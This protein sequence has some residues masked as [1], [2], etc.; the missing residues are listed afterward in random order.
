[1]EFSIPPFL[2]Y[3]I[4]WGATIGAVWFI[5]EKAEETVTA[6]TKRSISN[7]L[8][9]INPAGAV[10]SWPA[11]FASVFDRVF[12]ERHLSWRCFWR[13][14][15]ASLVSVTIM[16]FIWGIQ[17]PAEFS[18]FLLAGY[19]SIFKPVFIVLVIVNFILDYLSLLESRYVIRWMSKARS[20]FSIRAGLAIDCAASAV[21]ALASYW[22]NFNILFGFLNLLLITAISITGFHPCPNC[23][24]PWFTDPLDFLMRL[25]SFIGGI[26]SLARGTNALPD[27]A[28]F[29]Y[30]TFFTSVW[31]WLYAFSGLVVR[32]G[33]YFG[34]GLG[35]ID[36][37]NKPLRSLGLIS[38]ILVTLLYFVL[39]FLR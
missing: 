37:E 7:W 33:R 3:V 24:P 32:M 11:M 21:L 6:E 2:A 10:A 9:N 15:L 18:T 30:S 13:S 1:M 22:I 39:P 28:I 23:P 38:I 5:F 31:V 8:H 20:R 35:L 27:L 36:V 25:P 19:I 12:G 29:F 4:A 14:C 17:N 34:L 26:L 16:T